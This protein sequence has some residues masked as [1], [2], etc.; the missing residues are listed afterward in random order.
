MTGMKARI[1]NMHEVRETVISAEIPRAELVVWGLDDQATA[2]LRILDQHNLIDV[3]GVLE[4]SA[5]HQ[6]LRMANE[7]KEE[8][9]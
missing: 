9:S 6:R 5:P 7:L 3:S 8:F 4:R 1:S 2:N